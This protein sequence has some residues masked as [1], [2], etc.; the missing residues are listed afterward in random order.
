MARPTRPKLD[1]DPVLE[2]E[3]PSAAALSKPGRVLP[4]PGWVALSSSSGTTSLPPPFG[5]PGPL[6]GLFVPS[7]V[8]SVGGTVERGAGPVPSSLVPGLSVGLPGTVLRPSCQAAGT[9]ESQ[10]LF[11]CPFVTASGVL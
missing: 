7:P 11:F 1:E 2:T 4:P 3:Q 9:R 10:T 5:P 6:P 8:G